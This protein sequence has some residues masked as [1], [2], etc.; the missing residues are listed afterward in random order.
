MPPTTPTRPTRPTRPTTP[1]TPMVW[2]NGSL[3]A[4]DDARIDPRDQGFLLG[5]GIFE[6]VAAVD[7]ELRQWPRHLDRLRDGLRALDLTIVHDDDE[8]TRGA[9]ELVDLCDAPR[10]RLRLTVTAGV[11]PAGPQRG[12]GPTTVLLAASPAPPPHRP[13]T[14]RVVPWTRPRRS[15]LIGL[16]SVSWG[17]SA[18]M[19]R[20]VRA[21]GDEEALVATEDGSLSEAAAANVV[22]AIG[23]R[24]LTPPLDTGCLP[25]IARAVLLDEGFMVEEDIAMHDLG[26]AEFVLLV[27]ALGGARPVSR[28]DGVVTGFTTD[29]RARQ[30]AELLDA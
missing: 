12:T 22:V 1:T 29:T 10:V 16:K 24:L 19:L 5:D 4:I 30:A 28:L 27:S 9:R 6:T 23:G 17:D 14:V 21:F 18:A 15:P 3:M 7:G 20:H 26:R 25:G 13:V 8:L 2:L 11:G